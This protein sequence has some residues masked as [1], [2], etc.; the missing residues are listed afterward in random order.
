MAV[1]SLLATQQGS[2]ETGGT[3]CSAKA[4]LVYYPYSC[5]LI[6]LVLLLM[7]KVTNANFTP[8]RLNR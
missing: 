1:V 7:Q 2:V 5:Y 6:S 3:P 8:D 4:L